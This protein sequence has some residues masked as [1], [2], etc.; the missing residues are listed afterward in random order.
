LTRRTGR[1]LLVSSHSSDLLADP[2]IAPDETLLLTPSPDGTK[3][4]RAKDDEQIV[5]LLDGGA[6]MAEA[7]LPI[8]SPPGA[9][10]IAAFAD[11]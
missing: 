10:R 11:Q 4:T 8:V 5:A 3:V 2:G 6:T 9:D 1:Q 7:V